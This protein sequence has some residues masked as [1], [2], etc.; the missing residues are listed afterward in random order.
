MVEPPTSASRLFRKT[1]RAM[2]CPCEIVIDGSDPAAAAQLIDAA[3]GEVLRIEYKYSRYRAD[4]L[5][6]RINSAAG[7]DWV[8]SDEE[9]DGLLDYANVLYTESRGLFDITS[10]VLRRVWDFKAG[11]LPAAAALADTLKLIGWPRVERSARRV[12]LPVAGMELDFG[13]FG[14][15]YAVDRAAAMLELQGIRH[16]YVNLGGD[17]RILGP[18]LDDTA[19]LMGIQHPRQQ[20]V[21]CARLPLLQGALATSGDYE[22]F[23]EQDGVR[24]CHVLN[25]Q[26]GWPARYWQSISV[27]AP[28]ALVAG[29]ITTIAMLQ[30][31]QAAAYLESSGFGYLAIDQHGTY[32]TKGADRQPSG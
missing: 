26:T 24:Y 14:K 17:M 32:H 21:L 22:R 31:A 2:A 29:S 10:G 25:P 6:S 15:E 30:E 12:R 19:W 27:T 9:T 8:E 4:S 23:F 13:G 16:G 5:L 28:S 1:F 20:G 3:I 11:V 7:T 18:K